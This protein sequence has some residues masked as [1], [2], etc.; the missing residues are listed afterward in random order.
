MMSFVNPGLLGPPAVFQRVF[1]GP[2]EASQDAHATPDQAEV[3]ATRAAELQRRIAPFIL[4]RTAAVN[5]QYL[6]TCATVVVFCRP[7][8]A[9]LAAYRL[10]LYGDA[11]GI[12]RGDPLA[13]RRLLGASGVESA[14]AL[15]VISRLRQICNHAA[16]AT[17][18]PEVSPSLLI[19]CSRL[20][21]VADREQC[22]GW[23]GYQ[24]K[25]FLCSCTC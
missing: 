3:G 18:S 9:Q 7:T 8:A 14:A 22:N 13:L 11:E 6:P 10:E 15:S 17:T 25:G 5:E 1:V 21:M 24:L 23:A 20:V 19:C 2:I 16:F 12:C 4:R